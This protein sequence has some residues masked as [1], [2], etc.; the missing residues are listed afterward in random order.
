M[1]TTKI[2]S[3]YPL[4]D[5]SGKYDHKAYLEV[6]K[7]ASYYEKYEAKAK[8]IFEKDFALLKSL[9]V[10]VKKKNILFLDYT[11]K[12]KLEFLGAGT[13]LFRKQT[14]EQVMEGDI[15]VLEMKYEGKAYAVKVEPKIEI[16]GSEK[17][18]YLQNLRQS[19][20]F[21]KIDL[22]KCPNIPQIRFLVFIDYLETWGVAMDKI[23]GNTL[24]AY[25]GKSIIEKSKMLLDIA[26][27]LKYISKKNYNYHDIVPDNFMF[28]KNNRGYVIDY[29]DLK[30][31]GDDRVKVNQKNIYTFINVIIKRIIG[32]EK[33]T[34]LLVLY[35]MYDKDV[36][37]TW[38]DVIGTLKGLGGGG[39]CVIM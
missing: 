9:E 8:E 6:G 28:D 25:T 16:F 11:G 33:N 1:S 38:D 7:A 3:I 17:N 31:F 35:G 2:D 37:I 34:G 13:R 23:D 27:A 10:I 26:R 19:F 20:G 32:E 12:E 21:A 24:Y 36:K 14:K 15:G 5:P 18:E 22:G 4:V 39:C 30:P 29:F